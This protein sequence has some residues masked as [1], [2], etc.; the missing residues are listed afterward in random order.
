MENIKKLFFEETLRRWH[1][2]QIRKESNLSRERVN[3]FL[4]QLQKQGLIKRIKLRRKMP[5]HIANKDNPLFRVQ[6]RL[7]GLQILADSGLF[8]QLASCKNIKTAILFG[9][10]SRGDWSKS[11]DIDLFIYGD[12]SEF[13]KSKFESILK[14]E[15]QVFSFKEPKKVKELDSKLIPNI[16]KGVTLTESIEPFK[17]SINA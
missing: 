13:D 10:F 17:V 12:D 6:K 1:F 15:I 14:R 4:K 16:L 11:S 5:Y 2:E 8:T 7:Y 3:H 9:S